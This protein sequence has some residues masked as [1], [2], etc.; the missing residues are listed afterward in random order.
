MFTQLALETTKQLCCRLHR[1]V[2]ELW[3]VCFL[4]GI[5]ASPQ[6]KQASVE[7]CKVL[8]MI[9][10]SISAPPAAARL[11]NKLDETSGVIVPLWFQLF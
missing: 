10:A 7:H 5:S 3:A 4:Q 1:E 9:P 6:A 8:L 2:Y 11:S